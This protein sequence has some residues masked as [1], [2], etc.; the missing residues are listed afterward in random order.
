MRISNRLRPVVGAVALASVLV[1]PVA[2]SSD[3]GN[4]SSPGS[5]SD[6]A[7]ESVTVSGA[8]GE[9][10]IDGTPKRIVA[11]STTDADFV[12]AAGAKPIAVPILEQSNAAT[13]GT[14]IY[15]WQKDLYPADT[16][17]VDAPA[18][19]IRVEAVA[20]LKPDL[21]VATGFWGL[22]KKV[23]DSL[24]AIAPVL[25]FDTEANADPWQDNV[26]KVGKAVHN[27]EKA[28]QSIT[29]AES[30]MTAAREANP[31][32]AGKSYNAIISP[33]AD[34]VYVLCSEA[35]NMARAM[36]SLGLELSAYAKTVE[37]DGGKAEV[38]WENVSKL[39]ADLLWVI[40]DTPDQM[41][42]LD[43]QPL[44][45]RLPAVKRGAFT[46]VPKSEGV[47]FALGFPSPQSLEW[48]VGQVAPKFTGVLSK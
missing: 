6:A 2:C 25:H 48:G 47:P 24:T 32:L 27:P 46:V 1:L 33:S 9:S 4:P 44:W 18:T 26:R 29:G 40:P 12:F 11:L 7:N 42:V 15:P 41:S 19:D 39:D 38:S 3:S 31:K 16:P 10:K 22:D 5:S 13:G 43:S 30:A 23:Y 36:K 21:I 37:C 35:D 14:G 20:A 34:G 17:K 45:S 8:F 28:E